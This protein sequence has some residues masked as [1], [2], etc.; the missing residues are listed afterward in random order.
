MFGGIAKMVRE[1]TEA[2]QLPETL[3]RAFH[4]AQAGTPGP[5]VVVLPEDMLSDATDAAVVPAQP[6]ARMAPPAE[7]VDAAMAMLAR[8]RR[9]LVIAGGGLASPDGRAALARMAAAH[10]LPVATTFKHQDVFHNAS[11]LFAGHL[12][13]KIPPVL[14]DALSRADLILA[15]G[16][17]LGDTPTQGYRLPRAPVPEQPLIHVWPDP[18]VLGRVFATDLPLPCDPAAFC[19]A[20]AARDRGRDASAWAAEAHGAAARLMGYEVRRFEDGLDFGAVA[21][22]LA[23]QAPPGA[24]VVTDS[25]NFASWIHRVWPWDGATAAIGAAG[26]A[27]GLGVPGAVAACLRHP[28][29][30]VICVTGDGGVLMTGA[31]LATAAAHG[32]SPKVVICD[33]ATYGTIRLHQERAYP[34]AVSGTA[35]A[36]P[37]FAAWGRSFGAL[38]LAVAAAEDVD[39]AV[40]RLLSHD[41]PAVLHV[42]ASAEGISAFTTIAALRSAGAA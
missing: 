28:D 38:G 11:P 26:G 42:K 18:A 14:L 4:V 27:M 8:A 40:G 24:I 30:A 36:N 22:A 19:D 35:L 9:P 20:L 2:D 13:F 3:A 1:V 25:G 37:D 33:N 16:T 5:V 10:G 41:G 17:R 29:R 23:A 12:G 21:L 32:A 7:A 6:V 31:E 15:L 34:G 39:E